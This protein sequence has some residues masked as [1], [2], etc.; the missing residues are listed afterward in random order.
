MWDVLFVQGAG[1]GI[2]ADW[3]SHLVASLR[4][5]LASRAAG[6]EGSQP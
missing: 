1:E 4:R 2:H 6:R 3:D 5:G